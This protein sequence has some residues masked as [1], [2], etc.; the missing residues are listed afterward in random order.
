MVFS[1]SVSQN[2]TILFNKL[3]LFKILQIFRIRIVGLT[4]TKTLKNKK[5]TLSLCNKF[6]SFLA[7]P[8]LSL[9]FPY[10]LPVFKFLLEILNNFEAKPRT[11]LSITQESTKPAKASN[12]KL[13]ANL[14]QSKQSFLNEYTNKKIQ[15]SRRRHRDHFH[16]ERH[17]PVA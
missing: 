14:Y 11:S 4:V 3:E 17:A 1:A 16:E 2:K 9:P 12:S 5:T 13:S 6:A 10:C 7:S 8:C 15:M